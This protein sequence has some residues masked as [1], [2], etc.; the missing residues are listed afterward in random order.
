MSETIQGGASA[1]PS[2][3]TNSNDA[4]TSASQ[5]RT[6]SEWIARGEDLAEERKL[7]EAIQAFQM[8]LAI[9]PT[10]AKAHN[11]I[12]TCYWLDRDS[13]HALHHF[14]KA[15]QIEP[16][17]RVIALNYADVLIELRLMNVAK[18][19]YL[20][21]LETCPGDDEV[22]LF[23]EKIGGPKRS[24]M[25]IEVEKEPAKTMPAPEASA[26]PLATIVRGNVASRKEY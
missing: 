13:T 8:A 3:T 23:L 11:N 12:G 15:Y 24:T 25:S 14:R 7:D 21:Y 20:E 4:T 22:R 18:R 9:D 2:A 26:L 5:D 19:V 10:L 6:A 17:T 16:T 1:G